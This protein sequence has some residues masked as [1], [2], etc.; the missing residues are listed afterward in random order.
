MQFTTVW[1]MKKE[2]DCYF[3][4]ENLFRSYL[5]RKKWMPAIWSGKNVFHNSLEEGKRD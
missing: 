1:S 4:P 3:E 5:E 2:D